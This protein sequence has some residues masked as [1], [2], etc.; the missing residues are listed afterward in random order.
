MLLRKSDILNGA[1]R[2]FFEMLKGYLKA[3]DQTTFTN[4]EIRHVLRINPSNQKRYMIQLQEAGLVQK[5]KGNKRNGY[6][7]EVATYEDYSNTHQQIETLLNTTIK[8]L[9]V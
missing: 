4:K 2:N 5:A 3:N 1:C 7:Y 6:L 8:E 9:E